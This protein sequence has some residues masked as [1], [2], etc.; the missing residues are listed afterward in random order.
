MSAEQASEKSLAASVGSSALVSLREIMAREEDVKRIVRLEPTGDRFRY[1][2]ETP[3][4]TF[5]KFVVGTT[6][7]E[8]ADV[9]IESRCGL[10]STAE[11]VWARPEPTRLSGTKAHKWP[12]HMT[13]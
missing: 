2:I 7:E 3:F 9:R 8:F 6:D 1:L 12:G 10:L 13:G 11:E 4:A 5:P